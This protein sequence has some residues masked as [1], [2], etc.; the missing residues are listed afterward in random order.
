ME[1]LERLLIGL[2][3]NLTDVQQLN[4]ILGDPQTT[5]LLTGALVAL[6]A[7][8]PGHSCCCASFR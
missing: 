3:L 1:T 8:L 4:A 7:A 2:L 5:A 6:A